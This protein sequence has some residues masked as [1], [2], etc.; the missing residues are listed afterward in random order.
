MQRK[1][2]SGLIL[3]FLFVTMSCV[4]ALSID[5]NGKITK[6]GRKI[7]SFSALQVSGSGNIILTQGDKDTIVIETDENLQEYILAETKGSELKIS[8]K[9]GG[10][11]NHTLNI[12]ITVKNIN[13]IDLTGAVDIKSTTAIQLKDMEITASGAS[14]MK[15]SMNAE[16]LS[17]QIS[18][19]GE[20]SLTGNTKTIHS[21]INGA[22]NLK[23]FALLADNASINISGAG[24]AEINAQNELIVKI[25]GAGSVDYIG[26]PKIKQNISGTGLIKNVK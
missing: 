16:K 17:L 11:N 2:Y 18:G 1:I 6:Q 19:S 3:F 23:A 5:G 14:N 9:K 7:D 21:D 8:Q 22:G 4:N 20:I 10:N 24:H 25:S 26:N 15:L 13:K 12:F